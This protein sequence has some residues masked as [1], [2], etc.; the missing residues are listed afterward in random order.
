MGFAEAYEEFMAYHVARCR[1]ER[2]RR[3]REGHGH[4]ER[5]FLERV[6]WPA[7]RGFQGLHPEYEVFDFDGRR[8]FVDFAY[9][10]AHV[11]LALEIDGFGPHVT[12]LSRWQ[13]TNQLRRQNQLV[14]DDWAILRFSYDE[15][16]DQP[17]SCQQVLRSFMGRREWGHRPDG[18]GFRE[19]AVLELALR[20]GRPLRPADVREHLEVGRHLAYRLLAGLRAKGYLEPVQGRQRIHFY[21]VTPAFRRE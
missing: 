4:A 9:L 5:E 12:Q 16:R 8:S 7:F 19:R 13:F 1:G 15:V 11:K 2:R 21:R 18:L 6:W 20:L 10:S 17:R 14:L 3:L